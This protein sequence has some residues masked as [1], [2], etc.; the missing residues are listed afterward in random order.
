MIIEKISASVGETLRAMGFPQVEQLALGN[1]HRIM[2]LVGIAHPT[3]CI[4]EKSYRLKN[5]FLSGQISLFFISK[6]QP[7]LI[8]FWILDFAESLSAGFRRS[9][10]QRQILDCQRATL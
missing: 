3:T 8:P 6:G 2:V 9:D 4:S 10:F 1:A 5:I 7:F